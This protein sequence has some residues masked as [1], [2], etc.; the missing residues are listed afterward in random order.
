M[1]ESGADV[2]INTVTPKA[3]AQTIR[4]I[5]DMG[6]KPTH[7][8]SSISASIS[9]VFQPAGLE[10]SKGILSLAYVKD[11]S[12]SQWKSDPATLEYLRFMKTFYSQGDPMDVSNVYGY[13][14]AQTMIQV[15][16]QCADELTRENVMKQAANLTNLELP[17][18]LPGIRINTSPT[19]YV[20]IQQMQ[21]IRF[22]GEKWVAF[23][24]LLGSE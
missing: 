2:V 16:K 6:W 14:T 23:G 5:F 17:M 8:L 22:D 21:M 7:F 13:S 10:K 4:K 9:L 18:L 19:D 20:L 11:P 12:D 15:L 3:A 1:K 24:K